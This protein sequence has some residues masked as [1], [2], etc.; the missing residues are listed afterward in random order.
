MDE[1]SASALSPTVTLI[2]DVDVPAIVSDRPCTVEAKR[3]VEEANSTGCEPLPL[4]ST[5]ASRPCCDC[6]RFRPVASESTNNLPASPLW[7]ALTRSLYGLRP[8]VLNN[9]AV[10]GAPLCLIF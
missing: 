7:L 3:F 2:D 10:M 6:V 9:E 8:P 1:T 4:S 5:T